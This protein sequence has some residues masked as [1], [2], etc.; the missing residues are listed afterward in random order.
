MAQRTIETTGVASNV[1][2]YYEG[3]I[4]SYPN[5]M[6]GKLMLNNRYLIFHIYEPRYSGLL[7][8]ASLNS[9]GRVLSIALSSIMDINVEGG[10]RSKR[11]RP[12]WKNRGDFERKVSG[13]RP[14]NSHPGF[15]DDSEHF[16]TLLLTIETDIGVEIARFEVQNPQAWEKSL[17]NQ[18]TKVAT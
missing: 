11:S 17:R 12:N 9:T 14:I 15:L 16:S 5:I 18:L 6:V 4:A 7:E 2:V 8:T 13:D 3:H 10:I 1:F